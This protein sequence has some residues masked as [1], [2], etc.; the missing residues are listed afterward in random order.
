M[1]EQGKLL[2]TR[3]NA[4]AERQL[5]YIAANR[6]HHRIVSFARVFILIAFLI[7]WEVCADLKIIDSFFF[8]S[9]SRVVVSFITLLEKN[10]LLTHIGI[11]L[12][13]TI[14]S[15]L[16]VFFIS[17]VCATLLWYSTKL[18][19][20][21]EPYLV[22]L[23]SLPKSAL[24]PLL[25]VWLGTGMNTIIVAGIS[26]ALFGAIIN[27]YTGFRQVDEEKIKLIYTLGGNRR[28][29]LFKVVLPGS[30]PIILST[31][32]VN[33]GLALMR[34]L[35]AM[36]GVVEDRNYVLQ[37]LIASFYLIIFLVTVVF[38]L[39]VMVFGNLLAGV[40]IRHAPG[41]EALF[42]LLLHL[43]G[44]FSWCIMTMIFA[45]M[46]TYIPNCKLKFS[47]QI[48]GAVFSATSWNLFS[49]GFSI[50]VQ[51]FNAFDMYGSLTTIVI[52]MLWLYFCFYLFL[53]GAHI[54]RFLEPFRRMR[55]RT[56]KR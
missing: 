25:I 29:T 49:W 2:E 38:S 27:L 32:K 41:M 45:A 46:Y 55:E 8:S 21:L 35:N 18:T 42:E 3:E 26:V 33:I 47:H 40:V 37:R 53:I 44:I 43:R 31:M 11:T 51:H 52:L 20:I 54:N 12:Y 36:N 5:K 39:T 10:A 30:I 1:N 23:N 14:L 9:P 7:L 4:S 48:P 22:V 34:G 16:L 28:D 56:K 13:E 17:M 15:F 6:R 50:Y 19:E 24:A